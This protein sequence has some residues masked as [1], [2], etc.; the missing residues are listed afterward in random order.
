M[1]KAALSGSAPIRNHIA[2]FLLEKRVAIAEIIA[3]LFILLFL[4]T[5]LNKSFDV[6][7]TVNVIKKTPFLS[8]YAEGVAW[9]VVILEYI[10]AA[11]LFLPKTRKLGL[12]AST[13]LMVA[14]TV[15]ILYMMAFI[16]NLPC[17]CGG[18]LQQLTWT[19]HLIF[20]LSFTIL[21]TMGIWLLRKK[22]TMHNENELPDVVFT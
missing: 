3:S 5:A 10:V 11:L 20:N 22:N 6:S 9:V 14:F 17:S 12:Y 16:P 21:A 7:K 19:Q 15:Y 2:R 1:K 8:S 13:F 4:Y 18:V